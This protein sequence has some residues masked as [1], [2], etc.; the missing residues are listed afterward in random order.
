[1][2]DD[3]PANLAVLSDLLEPEGYQ[4]VCATSGAD[5]LR[6][7]RRARPT[8]VLLDVVMP[9][10]DGFAVCRELRLDP[11]LAEI[12]VVF[13]T[14][15]NES[16]SL[17]EG[18][19]AGAVDYIVK[20]FDADEVLARVRTHVG[21]ARARCEL[22]QKNRELAERV[23]ELREAVASREAAEAAQ[24]EAHDRLSVLTAREERRWN[25][26]GLLGRSPTLAAMLREV[27]RL[28]AFGRVGVLLVGETGTGK[29]LVARALHNGSPRASAPFIPV[30]CAALPAELI[31]SMF[32]GHVKGAF[33][34]ATADRKGFFELANG[35][36]LF[37]DE[38]GDMPVVLQAKLLRVLEDGRV[39]PV[40]AAAEKQVDVRVVAATNAALEARIAAGSFRRD[41]YFRLARTTLRLPPLRDRKDDIP[42]LAAHFIQRS[43]EDL[44]LAHAPGI[45]PA[46]LAALAAYDFP[47]NVRELR[48][49]LENAVIASSGTVIQPGHL[50]LGFD[51]PTQIA[52]H[53]ETPPTTTPETAAEDPAPVTSADEIP[54]NLEA[55]ERIL[56]Q[57][58]LAE[59]GGNIAEASRLLGVHRSRIYRVL[60]E[61][62]TVA[63]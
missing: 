50:R 28:Q 57:R 33:T 6:L 23:A 52:D 1:L 46:A 14:G 44:G 18:F 60:G 42:I 36:T 8:L 21:L 55:A 27:E 15:S 61:L 9:G 39:T 24:R 45:S 20:P 11:A 62:E 54:L 37:L 19:R 2:V 31:E 3:V 26:A 41:L 12:P 49:L 38:I 22:A 48:N 56:I 29:E 63:R 34:G 40:G 25:V 5:A 13:I 7:A 51:S 32:F 43:A 10:L 58:A 16:T 47:G 17:S 59:A 53:L 4:L 30:N 35:G